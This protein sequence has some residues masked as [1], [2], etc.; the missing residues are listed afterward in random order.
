MIPERRSPLEKSKTRRYVW[1]FVSFLT[2]CAWIYVLNFWGLVFG[3]FSYCDLWRSWIWH[4]CKED[5]REIVIAEKGF[6]IMSRRTSQKKNNHK[7]KTGV[8]IRNPFWI[9]DGLDLSVQFPFFLF[10]LN[11]MFNIYLSIYNF[12]SIINIIN[13]YLYDY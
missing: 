12:T 4:R 11:W 6:F 10:F 9:F 3:P 7:N 2:Y 13:F 8:K 5:F 1:L